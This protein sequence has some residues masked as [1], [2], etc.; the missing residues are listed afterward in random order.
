[1]GDTVVPNSHVVAPGTIVELLAP[2][3]GG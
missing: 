2:V 3:S 1:V